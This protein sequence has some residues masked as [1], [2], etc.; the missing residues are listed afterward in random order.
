MGSEAAGRFPGLAGRTAVVSG[1]GRG[2]GRE[3]VL[4]LARQ[5]VRTA[6]SWHTHQE[7]AEETAADARAAGAESLA[8]HADARKPADVKSLVGSAQEAFGSFEFVVGNAGIVRP[9]PLAFMTDATWDD[10][11]E[12]NLRGTF[13]LCRLAMQ[14]FL[15][16]RVAGAIVNVASVSSLRGAA[17]Q[18]HYAA[19]KAGIALFTRSLAREAGPHGIRANVVAPGLVETAMTEDIPAEPMQAF[20]GDIPMGRL[21][22]PEEVAPL[23]AFLLSDLASYMNGAV[24]TVDGGYAA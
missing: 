18:T 3:I 2:I 13:L 24:V 5:G 23:V 9:V 4:E 8:V 14:F 20:L 17:G 22:R 16:H 11:L 15:K 19:S 6:F 21:G 10:V 12:T 1:G 7:A